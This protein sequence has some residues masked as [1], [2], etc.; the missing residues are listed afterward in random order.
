MKNTVIEC[1]GG[2]EDSM[3]VIH[4]AKCLVLGIDNGSEKVFTSIHMDKKRV[5][6]LAEEVL[7]WL[8]EHKE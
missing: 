8:E 3:E 7:K 1:I 6:V 4:E 2:L 5:L